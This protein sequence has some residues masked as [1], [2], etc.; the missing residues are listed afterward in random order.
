MKKIITLALFLLPM[1]FVI[2]Q[3]QEQ[4]TANDSETYLE[5]VT[6]TGIKSSLINAIDIKRSNVGV[7]EAITAEDFGK[8]PDGNLAESLARVVGI[9]IDRSNV[10]GERVAVRGFGPEFN[11][12]TLNGRQMPT[13]PGQWGGGRSF[14][15]GDIASTRNWLWKSLKQPTILFHLAVLVQP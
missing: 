15:F 10:E 5:E 8:F 4:D 9:G 13:V 11:L 12:V 3:E 2:A 6:V 1:S 7:M 14:N